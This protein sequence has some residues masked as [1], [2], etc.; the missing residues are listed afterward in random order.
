MHNASD[1]LRCVA[2]IC[3]CTGGD[4]DGD[5]GG[6]NSRWKYVLIPFEYKSSTS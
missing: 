2:M 5:G 3:C 4:G 6:G 1:V